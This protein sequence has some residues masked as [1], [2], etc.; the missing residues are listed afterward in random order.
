MTSQIL[1]VHERP[2]QCVKKIQIFVYRDI[3]PTLLVKKLIVQSFTV[4]QKIEDIL[5]QKISYYIVEQLNSLSRTY[6]YL[7]RTRI[8]FLKG[9]RYGKPLE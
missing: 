8:F 2:C 5:E 9:M 1:V 3:I 6:D 7:D 4:T